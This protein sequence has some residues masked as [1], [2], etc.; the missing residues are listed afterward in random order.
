M[1]YH[2]Y[3]DIANPADHLGAAQAAANAGDS[4]AIHNVRRGIP[5]DC[6]GG[7]VDKYYD[8][9]TISTMIRGSNP[10]TTDSV[11]TWYTGSGDLNTALTGG[12]DDT[13]VVDFEVTACVLPGQYVALI[14]WD[15]AI[16]RR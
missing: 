2:C 1:E 13:V 6:Y 12:S 5:R 7:D 14:D 4:L 10:A 15:A 8:H 16:L 9:A 11:Y 3:V